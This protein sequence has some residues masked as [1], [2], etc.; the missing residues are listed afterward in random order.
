MRHGCTLLEA[1]DQVMCAAQVL[2]A[3]RTHPPPCLPATASWPPNLAVTQTPLQPKHSSTLLW[4]A[5]PLAEVLNFTQYKNKAG[6]DFS[7]M[8]DP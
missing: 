1:G 7:Q 4:Y 6:A 8:P 2:P 3:R 5:H